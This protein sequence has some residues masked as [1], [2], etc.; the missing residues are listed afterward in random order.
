[1]T[2]SEGTVTK[3][4]PVPDSEDLIVLLD[5]ERRPPGVEAGHPFPNILR[6]GRSG[7]VLWRC[8][9]LP[10]E[11]AWKCYLSVDWEGEKLVA[12]APSYRVILD[13][14]SGAIIDS[15]FTK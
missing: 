15:E 7:D 8:A 13:P 14:A 10:Q 3:E 1:M 5:P 12:A 2:S 11:T 9:L 6:I 4:L